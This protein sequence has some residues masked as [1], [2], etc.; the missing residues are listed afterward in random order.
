MAQQF[1]NIG[2]SA[3]KGDG[4]PLRTA[5]DKINDNFT[6][7]YGDIQALK[8]GAIVADVK[9]TIVGDDSTILVDGVNSSINLAG[10]V[11]GD[12]IPDTN[13]A[14][15]IGSATKRFKDLYLS[16]NTINLGGTALSI[17]AGKLQVGGTDV[18]STISFGELTNKPTTLAGYGITDVVAFDGAFGSLSGKPTSL[19]GYG[20][21]SNLHELANVNANTASPPAGKILIY[22]NSN[23]EAANWTDALAYDPLPFSS[24]SSKPTTVAGYGITDAFDGAFGSL[25]GTPTTIAGYGI[26]DAIDLTG[27]TFTGDIGIERNTTGT[28]EFENTTVP[29]D[30]TIQANGKI[31]FSG[32]NPEGGAGHWYSEIRGYQQ[33]ANGATEDGAGSIDFAVYTNEYTVNAQLMQMMNIDEDGVDIVRGGLTLGGNSISGVDNISAGTLNNHTIPGGSAGTLALTSD[34]PA[35]YTDADVD[36]HLNTGTAGNNEVLSWTGADYAWV[37]QSGGGGGGGGGPALVLTT[38]A[39]SVDQVVDLYGYKSAKI[40]GYWTEETAFTPQFGF[41]RDAGTTLAASNGWGVFSRSDPDNGWT[42]IVYNPSTTS[43]LYMGMSTD[44]TQGWFEIVIDGIGTD[45]L[46]FNTH[47][48]S[49]TPGLKDN[50]WTGVYSTDTSDC[51]YFK[52]KSDVYRYVTIVGYQ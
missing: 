34:I 22:V 4:E 19:S 38:T 12:I 29:T 50:W 25:S 32:Y 11:K 42:Q 20:I 39:T 31:R 43:N 1:I 13:V 28:F 47:T 51:R 5:F 45:T 35:G 41:F 9:G 3:N 52:F 14:Y 36:T 23:W 44:S 10:T 30:D 49:N 46:I 18:G 17:T 37:A 7:V 6:E 33:T 24:I 15:D 27:S 40:S 8:S 16:G 48:K 21:S 26:T 2:T